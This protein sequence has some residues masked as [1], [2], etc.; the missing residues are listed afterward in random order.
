MFVKKVFQLVKLFLANLHSTSS[1]ILIYVLYSMTPKNIPFFAY[2][3]PKFAG[4][5]TG[6]GYF[7]WP[8][9]SGFFC[10]LHLYTPYSKCTFLQETCP[11]IVNPVPYIFPYWGDGALI[12]FSGS[13]TFGMD[14]NADPDPRIRTS[15]LWLKHSDANPD[16]YHNLQ[17]LRMPKN[18]FF[19]IFFMYRSALF[20]GYCIVR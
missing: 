12:W 4:Y 2:E 8:I 18:L 1:K 16:R 20:H 10:I 3:Y 14:S 11:C 17:W 13:V 6:P 9:S 7:V 5:C 15:E 19:H